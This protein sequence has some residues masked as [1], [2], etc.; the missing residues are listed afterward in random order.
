MCVGY[1]QFGPHRNPIAPEVHQFSAATTGRTVQDSRTHH[2]F[3]GLVLE[4]HGK[5]MVKSI[6]KPWENHWKM[7]VY[8]LANFYCT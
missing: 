7:D 5:T 3:A 2:G 1:P 6:G 4:N 8:P